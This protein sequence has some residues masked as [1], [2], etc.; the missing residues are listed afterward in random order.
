MPISRDPYIQDEE[1]IRR[2]LLVSCRN[3][4]EPPRRWR[5]ALLLTSVAVGGAALVV[6]LMLTPQPTRVSVDLERL[7]AAVTSTLLQS[8][9]LAQLADQLGPAVPVGGVIAWPSDQPPPSDRWRVCDG[10]EVPILNLDDPLYLALGTTYGTV[11]AGVVLPD[12]RGM[13]LRGHG[14][15]ANPLGQMQMDAV[16]EHSHVYRDHFQHHGQKDDDNDGGP[17]PFIGSFA[18]DA[19]TTE[20]HNPRGETRPRNFSVVWLIRV[21]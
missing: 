2:A 1:E 3:V 20:A 18:D 21:E 16:G 12:F 8:K 10:S 4:A 7:E 14:G 15:A 6:S 11:T 17:H 5:W 19:R 13:F 9:V